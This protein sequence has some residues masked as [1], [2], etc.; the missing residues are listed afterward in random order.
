MTVALRQPRPTPVSP[1]QRPQ[2]AVPPAQSG[3]ALGSD[4]HTGPCAV[5]AADRGP[6]G[7]GMAVPPPV[8]GDRR[9]SGPEGERGGAGPGAAPG[10]DPASLPGSLSSQ[11]RPGPALTPGVG[12][13]CF[14][15]AEKV[16]PCAERAPSALLGGVTS[17]CGLSVGAAGVAG[18]GVGRSERAETRAQPQAARL[19]ESH[20]GL[21]SRCS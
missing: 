7:S 13:P 6:L 4:A 2:A 18:V 12:P 10:G 20:G 21:V 9:A 1:S 19:S 11:L 5:A 14:P 16:A 15:P 3:S 17:R 8:S